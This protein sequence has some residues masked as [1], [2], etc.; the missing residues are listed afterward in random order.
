MAQVRDFKATEDN[1]WAVENGDFATVADAAAIPQGIRIRCGMFLRECWLNQGI[2][3]DYPEVVLVKNP[4]PLV[5]R[6]VFAAEIS[7]TPDVINVVGAQLIDDGDRN[8]SIE[9]IVDTVYSTE[10]LPGQVV[11]P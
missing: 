6:G 4:D 7:A 9:Y 1:E 10:P 8:A 3:I 11:V 5:I 2:G